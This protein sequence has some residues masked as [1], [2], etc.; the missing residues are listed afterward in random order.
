MRSNVRSLLGTSLAVSLL[1]VAGDAAAVGE[2]HDG[3]PNWAE[4]VM[5]EWTNRARVD[6]QLEMGKCGAPCGEGACFKPIDPIGWNQGANHAARFH[7]AE[8]AKQGFFA[9]DS[10]CALVSNINALF[11]A[12]CDGS[13]ACACQA[14]GTPTSWS[15]RLSLFGVGAQGE[16]IASGQDPNGAFY[17][18]LYENSSSATCAY[19]GSNGH[20]WNILTI[21][22][23]MG[24]GMQG[25]SVGDFGGAPETGKI[26]SAA[27]YP[28]SG[29]VEFWAN[30][31]D[32]AGAPKLALLNVNGAC[33]PMT[34]ARGLT[35]GNA[36]YSAKATVSGC[37]RYYFIFQDSTGAQITYPTTG[38]LGAG[39]GTCADWD[40]TRP[41]AGAG[42]TCTPSCG[43]K[44]CG[45][46]G[47]GG[48]C[49]ACGGGQSCDATG[50]CVTP[51]P[52]CAAPKKLCGADC[53]DPQSNGANCGTCGHAC[54][55][56]EVCSAG[57]CKAGGCGTGLTQCGSGCVDLT[58]DPNN[59]NAC[60][61]VCSGTCTGGTCLGPDGGPVDPDGGPTGP[62]DTSSGLGCYGCAT[63][64]GN[65]TPW[66]GI[67]LG[68]IAVGLAR[69]RR[70]R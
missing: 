12:S 38:S 62:G 17:Q 63:T 40:T 55:T 42:C 54:A 60:G 19:S 1:A 3:F 33:Q 53:V 30:W 45:D 16:I 6:P 8:M 46:N 36:A 51:A 50:K 10:K 29:A 5:L 67:A 20:R 37:Q 26:P 15:S 21:K 25:P 52:T 28:Q 22:G 34:K 31:F 11:P 58:Q 65:A 70:R 48:S 47:C 35:D 4:R 68:L 2:G 44:V 49:G 9:H 23:A 57:A 69:G 14:S 7:S 13:A 39:G 41:A 18:W 27:H 56:G 66:I 32:A 64:E 61:S 24:Y 59:C 43:S